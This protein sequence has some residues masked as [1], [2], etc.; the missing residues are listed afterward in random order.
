MSRSIS[1]ASTGCWLLF[2]GLAQGQSLVNQ[3]CVGCHNEKSKTGN[4]SLDKLDVA[5][6]GDAPEVWEKVV[7]KLRAG[8]MP[9]AGMP[10]PD[11]A[12]FD[13]FTTKLETELNRAAAAKP[14]PGTTGLHRLNRAE[15]AN[16]IRDLLALD[17]DAATLLPADDSSEGFD[18]IAAALAV[19]PALV[20]RAVST[21]QK[22][23]RMAVGNLLTSPATVTYRASGEGPS[24]AH[25]D[26]PLGTQGGILAR[27]FFPLDAE[28]SIKVRAR[29]GG[30][31]VGGAGAP[32]EQ[33]ELVLNGERVKLVNGTSLDA[34]ISVKAGPQSIG[35][36]FVRKGPP[37]AD[38]V[39]Q[40]FAASSAVSS[41]VITGPVSIS[42]TDASILNS[43][44]A[45]SRI[46]AFSRTNFSCDSA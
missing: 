16:A 9:P 33:L 41:I 21:A 19:S 1:L 32:G 5:R 43:R 13:T 42:T 2:A 22:I 34:K 7:R 24:T 26:M 25:L 23:S 20:E 14:N 28:Y 8:M 17:V 46:A 18:N 31:G 39:W 12:T 40:V 29:S 3:Y 6:P 35:A 38:D 4:L 10:R 27:H 44:S 30:I 15:Y 45:C 11:R 37:G 36:A